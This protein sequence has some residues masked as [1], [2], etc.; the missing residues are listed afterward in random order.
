M[1]P[2][3][4]RL[5]NTASGQRIGAVTAFFRQSWLVPRTGLR[6]CALRLSRGSL[7]PAPL[8]RRLAFKL[9]EGSCSV[10]HAHFAIV[11][12]TTRGATTERGTGV[13]RAVGCAVGV[14]PALQIRVLATE[15]AVHLTGRLERSAYLRHARWAFTVDGT[16][17][18]VRRAAM[19]AIASLDFVQADRV[20]L[21]GAGLDRR[22]TLIGSGAGLAS[23][24]RR[25][26]R[27]VIAAGNG[28]DGEPET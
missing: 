19:R 28:D 12:A 14:T 23:G 6:A 5:R 16:T 17:I 27:T 18:R 3:Y 8:S 9:A 24:G 2:F 20:A 11:R 7:Q 4:F 25:C 26:T 10:R 21:E 13:V 15:E 1:F 22:V